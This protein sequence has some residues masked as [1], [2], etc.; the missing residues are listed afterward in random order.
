[1]ANESHS[2]VLNKSDQETQ[3]S[4]SLN[5]KKSLLERL[6]RGA[7]VRARFVDSNVSKLVAFQVRALRE[8]EKWSQQRLAEKIDSNQNAIY[9]AENPNYGKHTVTTLKKIAAVFDVALI[10][11]FVPF[12][13]LIDWVTETP[14]IVEGL[15]PAALTV[16]SFSAEIEQGI[17]EQ[18]PIPKLTEGA[19]KS[20]DTS[21]RAPT[22]PESGIDPIP[23]SSG[24]MRA[25]QMNDMNVAHPQ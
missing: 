4:T 2:S 10:V 11:R 3:Q 1:M 14:H 23:P 21:K 7:D 22:C 13:E 18:E 8:K 25:A 6:N 5:S 12:S 20:A 17:F 19:A 24:A 16:P 15:T 9:R